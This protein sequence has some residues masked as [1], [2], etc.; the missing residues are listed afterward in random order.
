V[1]RSVGS[2]AVLVGIQMGTRTP[3]GSGLK[4]F[5]LHSDKEPHLYFVCALRSYMRL[6]LKEKV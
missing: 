6:S 3:L 4:V 1:N 2:K 5:V